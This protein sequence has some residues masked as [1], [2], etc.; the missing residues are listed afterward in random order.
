MCGPARAISPAFIACPPIFPQLPRHPARI[1]G[2]KS[3]LIWALCLVPR[4]VIG[5]LTGT[6]ARDVTA[7]HAFLRVGGMNPLNQIVILHSGQFRMQIF[8]TNSFRRLRNC[9]AREE[10]EDRTRPTNTIY[11]STRALFNPNSHYAHAQDH[12]RTLLLF[13]QSYKPSHRPQ[14]PILI[15]I[16]I[17]LEQAIESP[18][19]RGGNNLTGGLVVPGKTGN[20]NSTRL[21]N[22]YNTIRRYRR[23]VITLQLGSMDLNTDCR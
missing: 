4:S 17:H 22:S 18:P 9:R 15:S 7:A 3:I 8:Q 16:L 23:Q 10:L 1:C 21:D 11:R 5:V 6:C 20:R 19:P 12:H 2:N 14:S 13:L